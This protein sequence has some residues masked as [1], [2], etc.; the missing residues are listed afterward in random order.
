[1]VFGGDAMGLNSKC[2][3]FF[4]SFK[5]AK[6]APSN[7]HSHHERF[8]EWTPCTLIDVYVCAF[9][10]FFFFTMSQESSAS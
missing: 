3:F 4:F 2:D 5:K 7:Q 1:M 10:K 6:Q 9:L 8:D